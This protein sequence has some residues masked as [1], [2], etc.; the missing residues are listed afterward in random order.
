MASKREIKKSI[1]NLTF[2]LATECYTYKFFH[3]AK[4]HSKTDTAL[5][6]IVTLRNSLI[7]RVNNSLEPKNYKKNR[8]HFRAIA[9]DLSVMVTLMD[10]IAG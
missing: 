8:T 1:N 3:P 7:Q 9:K 10:T 5:E 2:E 4:D 6:N